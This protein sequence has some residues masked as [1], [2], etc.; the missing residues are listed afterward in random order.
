M[1]PI[2]NFLLFLVLILAVVIG[3]LAIRNRIVF[4]MA[5]RNFVRRKIQTLI[6]IGGLMVGTA[7]I[8]SAFVVQDTMGYIFEVETYRSLGEI[9]EEI[10]GASA[11]GSLT[12]FSTELYD[13]V[14][15]NLS[16]TDGIEALAPT[17]DELCSVIDWTSDLVEPSAH[18]IGVNSSVLRSTAFGSLDGDGFYPDTLADNEVAINS[19][20]ASELDATVGDRIY[21]SASAKSDTNALMPETVGVNFTL[22]RI[23]EEKELFGKANYRQYKSVFMELTRAQALLNR[24]GEINTIWISNTGDHRGG[25]DVTDDVTATIQQVL[26]DAVGMREL[27]LRFVTE[28]GSLQLQSAYGTFD[29][30]Y[31]STLL[32]GAGEANGTWLVSNIV[33][34][35]RIARQPA[36]GSMIMGVATNE[37]AMPEVDAASI[38]ALNSSAA[39]FGL[40]N[41][42]FVNVTT[43]G[44]SGTMHTTEL[45]LVILPAG[46]EQQLPPQF[47]NSTLGFVNF[48]TSQS[49]IA[50]PPISTQ[51][52]SV[53][54]VSGLNG[55]VLDSLERATRKELD[56][57]LLGSDVNL[58]VHPLKADSLQSARAGGDAIGQ[59]FLV[60]S[61]FAIIAGIV[62]IINIFVMLGEERKSEM[63]MARAVGMKSKHLVRMYVF[64]GSLYAFLASII[65][66]LLGLLL[67]RVLIY[68]FQSIFVGAGED[69]AFPFYFEWSSIFT[70]FAVGLLLTFV[71]IFFT[72]R[73]IA[74]LNIIR[75][76]R[77]IPEPKPA[78]AMKRELVLGA[79]LLAAGALT[80]YWA[81]T[82]GEGVGWLCGP[83]MMF[84]GMGLFLFRFIDIRPAITIA[85]VAIIV[86]TLNPYELPIMSDADFSGMD[87]FI[88]SGV[89]LVLAAV[90]VVMFNSD[91]ILGALQRTIGRYKSMRATLKTAISYPL[92]SKFKTG[93][94]LGMFALIIFTVTVTA[95]IAAMQ[96]S[97]A[98]AMRKEQSGGYDIIGYTNPGTPF[99]NLSCEELPVSLEDVEFRQLHT[100]HRSVVKLEEYDRKVPEMAEFGSPGGAEALD[101]YYLLGVC[102]SML[103]E[104]D[105]SLAKR[106]ENYSSDRATWEALATNRS[107]CIVDGSKLS[108][109]GGAQAGGPPG[110]DTGG[111]YIGASITIANLQGGGGNRTLKVIG[112]MDQQYFFR[113]IAVHTPLARDEYNAMPTMMFVELGPG[114]DIDAVAKNLERSYFELGLQSIDI[115]KI[116][117][118]ILEVTNN[119]M[120]LMQ[121][122]LGIGLLIG[123]AGIGIISARNVV[124]RRQQIGMLRAIGYK[125]KMIATSFLLETSFI[126]I[127]AIVIGILLGIAIGWQVY[128]GGFEELGAS[129]VIPGLNLFIIAV[130][131]Y[132][133]TLIF[134]FSP[135]LRAAR[136]PPAEALRYIE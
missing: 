46:I 34:T 63:G 75:A 58:E 135:A 90:L 16:S 129:Y 87:V 17:L 45:H 24:D 112:I 121:A 35:L 80:T 14:A 82:S 9:D 36:N 69:I 23:I 102:D 57:T 26:D 125:K 131:A 95:M 11:Q 78:R 28:S 126:T 8:S 91:L 67:G 43:M 44:L 25:E 22:A 32:E 101:Q 105:F 132:I 124:E 117:D 115:Q 10:Y 130:I 41:D 111:V 99:T 118:Q 2:L 60:F 61:T 20:L 29:L 53:V 109:G 113:G 106:D 81:F 70:A 93:M 72:S 84:L 98:E 64:E 38:F 51:R 66:A 71:T 94:T 27:G 83:P 73:R 37:P 133:A 39:R 18:L 40:T 103:A 47:R 85:G 88:A 74:K 136:I 96:A 123:I 86:W 31:A 50:T 89:F 3:V 79:L 5:A 119:I 12:Y 104:N 77:R 4:K 21:L 127:L 76:I 7:I 120:Y 19:R 30:D 59:I 56:S 128:S 15:T 1:D 134:T 33:P 68:A 52:A 107:L 97:T 65:G 54:V 49:M 6:V 62:L 42:T 122:F 114:E 92:A 13:E 116:I 100:V 110:G 48:T 108:M 55:S